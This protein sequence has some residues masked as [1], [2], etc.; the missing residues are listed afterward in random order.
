M[1]V[2]ALSQVVAEVLGGILLGPS[3][4]G[5]I[6]GYL[7]RIFPRESLG[8]F[9]LVANTG[10]VGGGRGTRNWRGGQRAERGG[11]KDSP[12][13][14]PGY[15]VDATHVVVVVWCASIM[16]QVLYL[17]LVGL[18]LDPAQIAKTGTTALKIA[19]AGQ[20]LLLQPESWQRCR[21]WL[22]RGTCLDIQLS[23]KR[24]VGPSELGTCAMLFLRSR[25][26]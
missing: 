10:L 25:G 18:E 23:S 19:L 26:T 5:S 14:R 2:S 20:W 13:C 12:G 3:A 7:D 21:S 4:L 17:F 9:T 1:S 8:G 22:L 6:P 24:G 15:A 16:A 11:R